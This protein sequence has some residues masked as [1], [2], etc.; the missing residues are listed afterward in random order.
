MHGFAKRGLALA[1][2]ASGLVMGVGG[3]AF[4]DANASGDATNSHGIGTGTVVGT[5]A[6]VPVL[7]CGTAAP[8][9]GFAN[10]LQG[11]TCAAA[12]TAAVAGE[13]SHNGGILAGNVADV[14]AAVPGE[15]CGTNAIVGGVQ[16]TADST[17]C[18]IGAEGPL[19]SSIASTEHDGGIVSGNAV[20][21]GATVPLALCGNTIGLLGVQDHVH[22]TTCSIS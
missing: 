2:A 5:A 13:S 7:L 12:H 14:A 6:E 10:E 11:A 22:G 20:N 8:V 17:T 3:V 21:V 1:A 18:T 15:V 19:V 16:E 9:A 4:A